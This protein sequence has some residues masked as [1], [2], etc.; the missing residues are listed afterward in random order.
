MVGR[1]TEESGVTELRGQRVRRTTEICGRG[2][3]G[4]NASYP[5]AQS[6]RKGGGRRVWLMATKQRSFWGRLMF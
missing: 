2:S 3:N 5:D 1:V 6:S 4:E